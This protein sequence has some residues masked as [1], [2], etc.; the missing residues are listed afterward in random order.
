MLDF[1]MDIRLG[2][3][4]RRTGRRNNGRI[5]GGLSAHLQALRDQMFL[6][7]RKELFFQLVSLQQM[8]KLADRR[9]IR[10]RLTVQINLDKLPYGARVIQGLLDRLV[11]QVELQLQPIEVQ[12][13]VDAHR[14]TASSLG[15]EIA[16]CNRG[17][18]FRPRHDAICF[19][20][21]LLAADGLAIRF[22]R[23][24]STCLWLYGRTS[25]SELRDSLA[26]HEKR[27]NQ[28]CTRE[29]TSSAG[30]G[31]GVHRARR[32]ADGHGALCLNHGR[33]YVHARAHAHG[34][35]SEPIHARDHDC[36]GVYESENLAWV[37][38]L[39]DGLFF[40]IPLFLESWNTGRHADTSWK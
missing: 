3:V 39:S 23:S 9:L 32:C 28:T 12:H 21:E 4:L 17:S 1:G 22:T 10:H 27:L 15:L 14:R 26:H 11:R 29:P 33:E 5:H 36:G 18:Q 37:I 31:A 16:P 24:L 30:A 2:A 20:E 8:R 7:S 38:L 40:M 35:E 25:S 13:A 19:V 6:D 34:C